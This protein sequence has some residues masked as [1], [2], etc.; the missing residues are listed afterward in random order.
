MVSQTANPLLYS[1]VCHWCSF[2]TEILRMSTPGNKYWWTESGLGKNKTKQN[3]ILNRSVRI[4]MCILF[5]N[6]VVCFPIIN[7]SK[8]ISEKLEVCVWGESRSLLSIPTLNMLCCL[9]ALGGATIQYCCPPT[10]NKYYA[11]ST[12]W[13]TVYR[14][15]LP[16]K[17]AKLSF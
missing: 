8:I 16:P 4:P 17:A 7:S 14:W 6:T 12:W 11:I 13:C 2:V 9:Q 5:T 1:L 15:L 10:P 3:W